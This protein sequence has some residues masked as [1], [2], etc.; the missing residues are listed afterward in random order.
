M[1]T[2]YGFPLDRINWNLRNGHRLDIIKLTVSLRVAT[3]MA[4]RGRGRGRRVNG[5][6]NPD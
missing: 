5:K 1:A 2:L 6:V 4:F 3:M